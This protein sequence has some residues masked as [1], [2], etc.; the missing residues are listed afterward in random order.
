MGRIGWCMRW[1]MQIWMWWLAGGITTIEVVYIRRTVLPCRWGWNEYGCCSATMAGSVASHQGQNQG[2]EHGGQ[3]GPGVSCGGATRRWAYAYA[4][5]RREGS[6]A[7]VLCGG[8][9]GFT[10]VIYGG[11]GRR[12]SRNPVCSAIANEAFN[13]LHAKVFKVLTDRYVHEVGSKPLIGNGTNPF[14][15]YLKFPN[16]VLL[17]DPGA[18]K[19]HLFTEF[20]KLQSGEFRPAR[21]FLNMSAEALREKNTF[22]ID[23]LDERRSDRGDN[24]ATDEI[25]K[26]LF[27][28]N[29]KKVR[30]SCRAADWLG[31]TDLVAF[32]DY[33]DGSGGYV[34]LNL[35][36]LSRDEQVVILRT[37]AIEDT[38]TFL[39][40]AESKGLSEIL[41]NPQ[42]LKMLAEVVS[43]GGW[44]STRSELF[45]QAVE[46]LLTETNKGVSQKKQG[47]YS[48]SELM[49][50]AGEMCAVRL[51]GDVQAIGLAESDAT[52]DI[53]SYRTVSGGDREKLVAALGR[54]VFSMGMMPETVDYAHRVIAE[55]LAA[56]W[57]SL[58]V[59]NGLP[60]GR[61][62]ALIGVDG[63]PATELRGLH[64]WLAVKLPEYAELLINAD[65]FGILTYADARAL[66]PTNRKKLLRALANLADTDPWF[67]DGHW[68][69]SSLAGFAGMDMVEDFRSILTTAEPNCSLRMLVLD[70]L[71]VGQPVPQLSTELL[72]IVKNAN[73]LY[74]ERAS[75]VDALIYIGDACITVLASTY[76]DIGASEDDVRL[77]AKL[78]RHL[79]GTALKADLLPKLLYEVLTTK[80]N[81]SSNV[82]YGVSASVPDQDVG[83]TLD[84]LVTSLEHLPD[85]S[86][87]EGVWSLEPEFDRLI[88]R[89]L[90]I[91]TELEGMRLLS[92]LECRKKVANLFG[93]SRAQEVYT[94]LTA[95][96]EIAKRGITAALKVLKID[97][98]VWSFTHRLRGL[99]LLGWSDEAFLRSVIAEM[100][101]EVAIERKVH[102]YDLA[103]NV[104]VHQI[105][106]EAR[107]EFD[108]LFDLAEGDTALEAVR[109]TS[110]YL[111]IPEWRA[112]DAVR[113]KERERSR[114]DGRAKNRAEFEKHASNIRNGAHLGW[115]GWIA[116]VYFAMFTD[117]NREATPLERLITELGA[118]NAEIAIEGLVALVRKEQITT[119]SEILRMRGENK[120]HPWWYAII[121]GLDLYVEQGGQVEDLKIE[122]LSAALV[123]DS[124]CT[125]FTYRDNV[126]TQYIHPWKTL[127][128]ES[129]PALALG[130]YGELARF[131]LARSAQSVFGLHDLLHQPVLQPF[132][133]QTAIALLREFPNAPNN[134]LR[135]LVQVAM[136]D[137]DLSLFSAL[138]QDVVEKGLARDDTLGLWLAAGYVIAP[139][140][141]AP[142]CDAL[143]E[144]GLIAL[145]W[146][147]RDASGYSRRTN[148]QASK[149]SNQQLEQIL[150][151]VV[152][153]FPRT[154]HPER[155]WSGDENAWDATDF[156]LRLI[157]LLS[158]DPST[159]AA[160]SLQRFA[161]DPSAKSY[162]DDVKHAAAQQRVRMIDAQYRQPTVEQVVRTLSNGGPSNIADLHALLLDHLEDLKPHIASANVDVFKRFW[163]EDSY[164]KVTTPKNEESCRDYLVELLRARTIAQSVVL[165]PEGHMAAD[166]RA[167]IIAL[168]PGMKLVVELKRDYHSEVW[169]AIQEQLERFYMRD[170][171]AKGYGIYVVLWFG[172]KRTSKICLP[173]LSFTRPESASE[174]QEILQALIPGEKRDKIGVV[175]LDVSGGIPTIV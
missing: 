151:W 47:R 101:I 152:E 40:H 1:T 157:A 134:S 163:N 120:Y 147:L 97:E 140:K 165:E 9:A 27:Q 130:A 79:G 160:L 42:N 128:I 145:V 24:N 29:P 33:F 16:I 143:D 23:A 158:A 10:E 25:V 35:R 62:R 169:G 66:T 48:A 52:E 54:R 19:T 43:K 28:V 51:I 129:R 65:P 119:T 96:P 31:E 56:S 85:E 164:G 58:K 170:P 64:A 83:R 50:V 109:R 115:L 78:F 154:S 93:D 55:Y 44:P 8:Y 148:N 15:S 175:V 108:S 144:K 34:V 114:A 87:Q 32:K 91:E 159:G 6:G 98:N 150:R 136:T 4:R 127:V 74:V 110:C 21:S 17:G 5:G 133:E 57:L 123:I 135:Q 156:A 107:S 121:A 137:R 75:A 61:V 77:K 82:L 155:G 12:H 103:L 100:A 36:P 161:A 171:E 153:R 59:R 3:Q 86:V 162:L 95:H 20:A 70:S 68:T 111:E 73:A 132:R 81:N 102:L 49:E 166:K 80:V 38:E 92:W 138:A 2:R 141:F 53:P 63:R 173:P 122:F 112:K 94:Q 117:V 88:F 22:F 60:I 118:S 84:Q 72:S 131:D 168:L 37:Y 105:G 46:I 71:A 18:G 167:D 99:G 14:S 13:D 41:G 67:R 90:E 76:Q 174:M 149:L 116:Q 113:S 89:A 11:R 142:Y 104:A 146:A 172:S 45:E 39:V 125:T 26:K 126:S 7:G 124:L 106:P 69:S 139:N 30:I